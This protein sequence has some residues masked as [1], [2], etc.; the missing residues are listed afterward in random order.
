MPP[1]LHRLVAA[2][3]R[4]LPPDLWPNL[5]LGSGARVQ[6]ALERVAV[7]S[8]AHPVAHDRVG[9]AV[10]KVLLQKGLPLEDLLAVG[11]LPVGVAHLL[12]VL[13]K[14]QVRARASVYPW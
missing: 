13:G 7:V 10:L 9:M 11:A 4:Q 2:P 6:V 1:P 8:Q 12:L 5:S 14:V 3:R